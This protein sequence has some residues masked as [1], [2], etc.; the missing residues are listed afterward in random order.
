[1]KRMK[2]WLKKA[3]HLNKKQVF[4]ALRRKRIGHYNYYVH[5]MATAHRY[6]GFAQR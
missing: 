6:G 4:D 5:G 2:Q 1:M 3:R